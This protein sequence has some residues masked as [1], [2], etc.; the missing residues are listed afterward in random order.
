MSK[1]TDI[2][3]AR[4]TRKLNRRRKNILFLCIFTSIVVVSLSAARLLDAADPGILFGEIFAPGDGF[5]VSLSGSYIKYVTNYKNLLGVL[6]DTNFT[7][8]SPSA[9]KLISIQH[10]YS[11]PSV[12]TKGNQ[13]LLF[14]R[15]GKKLSVYNGEQIRYA[16]DLTNSIVYCDVSK[17]GK[18]AAATGAQGYISQVTVM[19]VKGD[20]L[21]KWSSLDNYVMFVR[22]MEDG[23]GMIVGGVYTKDGSVNTR[24]SAFRFDSEEPLWNY[25]APDSIPYHM[26]VEG[27]RILLVTD[28]SVI[29]LGADGRERNKITFDGKTL[30]AFKVGNTGNIALAL[31]EYS[32]KKSDNIII[33]DQSLNKL[34]LIASVDQIRD[35]EVTASEVILL[36]DEGIERYA[37][38]GGEKG[39]PITGVDGSYLNSI[40]SKIYA[41]TANGIY[42]Y[43]N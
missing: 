27:S 11:N 33:Y 23:K 25:E 38:S 20:D 14:D 3:V 34:G 36:T 7:V 16:K 30:A 26:G 42:Q 40:G 12:Q 1:V 43:N 5:P 2:E 17:D 24:L 21:F 18:V 32:L 37:L 10:S 22:F 35:I 39:S 6:S 19:D 28:H 8:F 4:K 15:G 41:I 13:V 31:T 9:K 29:Q